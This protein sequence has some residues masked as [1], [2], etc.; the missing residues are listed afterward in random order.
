MKARG[1]ARRAPITVSKPLLQACNQPWHHP[2]GR[3]DKGWS[4]R[5]FTEMSTRFG[6][7]GPAPAGEQEAHGGASAESALPYGVALRAPLSDDGARILTPA[8]LRFLA[9]LARDFE[10]RRAA[11]LA[12]RRER[13]QTLDTGAL[14]DFLPE[15]RDVRAADWRVAPI[16][17]DLLDR[18]VEITGPVERKMIINA[19][20]SGANVFM[21]DFEDSLTPTWDNVVL[22]QA[23]LCDAVQGTIALPGEG[24]RKEALGPHPC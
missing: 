22:G 3:L 5:R 18:R 6:R 1:H 21:A 9:G 10:P 19:L 12:R 17:A 15:P 7:N 24:G 4:V 14:P 13:Q 8:A 23:H 20:N 16:P 2:A 11:L